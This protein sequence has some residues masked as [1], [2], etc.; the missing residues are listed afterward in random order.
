MGVE[1]FV[2]C[3]SRKDCFELGKGNWDELLSVEHQSLSCMSREEFAQRVLSYWIDG[4]VEDG[5][6]SYALDV[7][8]RLWDWCTE[9]AWDVVLVNDCDGSIF[10]IDWK[11]TST[12]FIK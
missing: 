2:A 10:W 6:E 12:R 3:R 11:I 1:Y 9:R 5:L 7:G 4:Y 8:R